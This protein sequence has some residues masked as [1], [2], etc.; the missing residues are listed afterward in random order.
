ML[1]KVTDYPAYL[2]S[3]WQEHLLPRIENAPTPDKFDMQGKFRDKW[4]RIG[5]SVPPLFMRSIARH[6]RT[7]ILEK[8]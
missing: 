4:M 3:C 5:N 2:E 6:I 8:L 7:E 1:K